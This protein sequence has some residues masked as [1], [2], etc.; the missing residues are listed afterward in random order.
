[1]LEVFTD[2]DLVIRAKTRL[3]HLVASVLD[4]LD[5]SLRKRLVELT[6]EALENGV[7]RQSVYR[8]HFVPAIEVLGSV[9]ISTTLQ[10]LYV[11][12]HHTSRTMAEDHRIP[13]GM[14]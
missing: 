9:D 10:W 6:V 11:K 12:C 5:D 7:L 13:A 2:D 1:M 3:L 4:N 14:S 8:E